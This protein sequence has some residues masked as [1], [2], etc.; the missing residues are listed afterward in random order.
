MGLSIQVGGFED[1]EMFV[2]ISEALEEAGLAPHREP[3]SDG[4]EPAFSCD[5]WGYSGL[6]Y[7]RRLAAYIGQGLPVPDLAGGDP[8]EDPVLEKYYDLMAPGFEH[9]VLH[10]DAE[11][12]YVP[13][14]FAS[15]V[16]PRE[17]IG[18]PG[19]MLGSSPRLLAECLRLAAWLELPPGLDPE[20]EDVWDAA[21]ARQQPGP[22]WM[23]HGIESFTCLRLMAAAEASVATGSAIVFC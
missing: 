7:V 21:E 1:P 5:M 9:L 4:D 19:G 17:A 12:F 6:H 13:Q 11:G 20:S 8:A 22:K 15:V 10:S 23:Q 14:D 3:P 18:L 16:F 2:Q